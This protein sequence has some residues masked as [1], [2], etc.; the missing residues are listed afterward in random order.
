MAD[1]V[2]TATRSR[3]MASVRSS[4]TA[5]EIRVRKAAHRLGYRFRLHRKSLAGTPDLTFPGRNTVIFVHGCFWHG[6][7]CRRGRR[8]PTSNVEYWS[9]K[10]TRNKLRDDLVVAVLDAGGWRVGIVWECEAAE[11]RLSETLTALL[12]PVRSYGG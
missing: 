3:I 1:R 11:P 12:G 2:D 4:N 8:K 5:T 9:E 10:I 6:H 7:G